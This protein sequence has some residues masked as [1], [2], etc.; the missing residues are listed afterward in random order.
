MTILDCALLLA[1]AGLGFILWDLWLE[2]EDA[3]RDREELAEAQRALLT[4]LA[5]SP[6]APPAPLPRRPLRA[7]VRP[8]AE[9]LRAAIP[10]GTQL[11]LLSRVR[12]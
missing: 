11:T 10:A 2:L 3:R 12:G 1:L 6:A 5:S 4:R 8:T 9:R 7:A